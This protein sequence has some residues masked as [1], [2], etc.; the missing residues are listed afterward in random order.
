MSDSE[1][2]SLLDCG[3]CGFAISGA[4]PRPGWYLDGEDVT[5]ADCGTVNGISC[6][7]E[8]SPHVSHWT[9]KHGKDDEEPCDECE[10]VVDEPEAYDLSVAPL[11]QTDPAAGD[12]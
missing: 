6:D 10:G 12:A 2:Y 4:D 11:V 7:S 3:N 5:C 9:C 1:S 8:E